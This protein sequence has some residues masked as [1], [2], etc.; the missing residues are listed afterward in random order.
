MNSITE[1]A[2][3]TISYYD[4]EKKFRANP[5]SSSQLP[6]RTTF[7]KHC[8]AVQRKFDKSNKHVMAIYTREDMLATVCEDE[9][10]LEEW[11]R[12]I[13]EVMGTVLALLAKP[14][15]DFGTFWDRF[16]HFFSLY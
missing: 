16:Y 13:W 8:W 6:R 10:T 14:I 3:A 4:T 5:D 7:I 2:H 15:Y 12:A 9:R 11:L 1:K